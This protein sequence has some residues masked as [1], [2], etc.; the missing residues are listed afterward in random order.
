MT[1]RITL[2]DAKAALALLAAMPPESLPYGAVATLTVLVQQYEELE[3]KLS[4]SYKSL[5]SENNRLRSIL[6]TVGD[7]LSEIN[8]LP[9][10]IVIVGNRIR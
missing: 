6:N 2:A 4:G 3:Y 8:D 5:V 10:N 1:N 7:A 9:S